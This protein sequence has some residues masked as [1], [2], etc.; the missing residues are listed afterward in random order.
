ML[1][2]GVTGTGYYG[3]LNAGDAGVFSATY[4][5][6]SPGIEVGLQPAQWGRIAPQIRVGY[7]RFQAQDPDAQMNPPDP[8]ETPEGVIIPNTFA[9][10]TL[11]YLSISL[12]GRVFSPKARCTPLFSAG[13]RILSFSS[14]NEEGVPLAQLWTTRLPEERTLPSLTPALDL[15]VGFEAKLNGN[16]RLILMYHNVRSG[17]DYIDNLGMLGRLDGN[18]QLHTLRLALGFDLGK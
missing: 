13:L 17:S 2:V 14:R 9:D 5:S 4:F 6:V 18:D 12:E 10:V 11:P 8:I 3:D 1:Q 15:G 7:S 16:L